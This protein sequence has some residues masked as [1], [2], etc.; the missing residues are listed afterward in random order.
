MK[1]G[2]KYP[3]KTKKSSIPVITSSS[4]SRSG[5]S[6]IKPNPASFDD[7]RNTQ[8]LRDFSIEDLRNWIE[9]IDDHINTRIAVGIKKGIG[10]ILQKIDGLI[11]DKVEM[12]LND[13]VPTMVEDLINKRKAP[14]MVKDE[15]KESRLVKPVAS[16]PPNN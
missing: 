14:I 11:I 1:I 10:L 5:Y 13:K 9:K 16:Y 6:K 3:V 2:N 7:T 8:D 4:S 15:Q 12:A